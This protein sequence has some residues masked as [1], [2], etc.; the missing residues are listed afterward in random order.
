MTHID[1]LIWQYTNL[2]KNRDNYKNYLDSINQAPSAI[3]LSGG[4]FYYEEIE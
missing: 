1:V 4:L 3:A 2:R